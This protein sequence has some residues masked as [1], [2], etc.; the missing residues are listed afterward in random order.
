MAAQITDWLCVGI[1]PELKT[2]PLNT[3]NDPSVVGTKEGI[4]MTE[5]VDSTASSNGRRGQGR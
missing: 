1:A 4:N 5:V 3:S 2:N